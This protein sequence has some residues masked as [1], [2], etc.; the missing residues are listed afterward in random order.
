MTTTHTDPTWTAAVSGR[1]YYAPH[2]T[3]PGE[4]IA[5]QHGMTG[6]YPSTVYTQ[7]HADTL[8]ERQGITRAEVAA[9]VTCSMFDCWHN[10][11]K[12]ATNLEGK[13]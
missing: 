10:F 8:N 11:D 1:V 13:Q 12:I 4:F 5:I 6:Y 7:E 2:T 3:E 9:A